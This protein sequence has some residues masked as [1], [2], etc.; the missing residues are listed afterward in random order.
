MA[1]K[2]VDEKSFSELPSDH[3]T[4]SRK[5]TFSWGTSS[6]GESL[7]QRTGSEEGTTH[8]PVSEGGG[9]SH[10]PPM[11]SMA[12][13]KPILG[14]DGYWHNAQEVAGSVPPPIT[15]AIGY[16]NGSRDSYRGVSPTSPD[17]TAYSQEPQLRKV[18][19]RP[20][21]PP[22]KWRPFA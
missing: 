17:A 9:F 3:E 11:P 19:S 10:S 8:Q 4:T 6:V 1:V 5:P 14:Q 18:Q 2:P 13:Q 15:S 21:V 20:I 12:Y 22:G 16:V 7:H